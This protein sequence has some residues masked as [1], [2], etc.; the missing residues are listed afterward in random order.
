M[1]RAFLTLVAFLFV[2]SLSFGQ[3]QNG[4]V[5]GWY[6]ADTLNVWEASSR[7]ITSGGVP[8]DTNGDNYQ[9][10]RLKVYD[11]GKPS[12]V[13]FEKMIPKIETPKGLIWYFGQVT[14]IPNGTNTFGS[15]IFSVG[16]S[17]GFVSLSTA[18]IQGGGAPTIVETGGYF[19]GT[20]PDS[21]D[22]IRVRI[23]PRYQLGTPIRLMEIGFDFLR[24]I[25]NDEFGTYFLI[26]SFNEL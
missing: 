13:E 2:T 8:Q 11:S 6:V 10:F 14:I 19:Q 25:K 3:I 15:Y 12:Y 24:G 1:K 23:F 18:G 9:V 22:R 5:N 7:I 4:T 16:N 21:V 26:D 17:D 20:L